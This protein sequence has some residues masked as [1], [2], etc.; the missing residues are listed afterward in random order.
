MTKSNGVEGGNLNE[1]R[2][3]EREESDRKKGGFGESKKDSM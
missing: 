2:N 1:S 3:N